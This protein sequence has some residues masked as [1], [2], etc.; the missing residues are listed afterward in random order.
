MKAKL[1][2]DL[3]QDFKWKWKNKKWHVVIENKYHTYSNHEDIILTMLRTNAYKYVSF[4]D[5]PWSGLY[6]VYLGKLEFRKFKNN[7]R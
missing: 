4:F 7:S 1:L 5:W 2:K 6:K 3:R